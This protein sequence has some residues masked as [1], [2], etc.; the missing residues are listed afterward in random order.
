V[1]HVQFA[2]RRTRR[3]SNNSG[4]TWTAANVGTN[5]DSVTG[6]QYQSVEL[7]YVGNGLF[8][9]TSSEGTFLVQ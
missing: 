7:Q 2:G 3:C 9:I 4:L 8:S 5:A 1:T 6:S